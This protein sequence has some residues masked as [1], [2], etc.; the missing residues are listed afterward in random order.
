MTTVDVARPRTRSDDRRLVACLIFG[1]LSGATVSGFGNP[2]VPE[3]A[4]TQG[5]S[6]EAAQWT[7]TITLIVGAIITPVVS[8][9]GDGFRRRR[10]FIAA[11]AAIATGSVIPAVFASFPGLLVGRSLQGLGYALVPITIAIASQHLP[12]PVLRRTLAWLSLS[13]AIGAGLA[14]PIIGLFVRYLDYRAA[15]LFAAA[16]AVSGALVAW[17]VVPRSPTDG[18]PLGVDVPGGVLLAIGLGSGL[19]AVSRGDA[20]GWTSAS[21]VA[22]AASSFVALG[23]WVC[24]ELRVP[25]PLVDVRLASSPHLL[26]VNVTALTTGAAVFGGMSVVYRL[27]Q[28]PTQAPAGLGQPLLVAGLMMLPLSFGSVLS[29]GLCRWLERWLSDRLTLALASVIMAAAFVYFAWAHTSL[30][31]I[32]VVTFVVGLGFGIAYS[33][34]PAM[35]VATAPPE[36]TSSASGVN[37]VLRI[38]GG[39][40]GGAVIAA[41]LAASTPAGEDFPTEAGIVVA[42]ITAA[43]L[44]VVAMLASLAFVR[45]LPPRVNLIGETVPD[46]VSGL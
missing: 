1:A 36:R 30:V 19:L 31:Q 41:L 16:L 20:W 2:L 3:V 17:R 6:L 40:I 15:F 39:A 13:V 34:M 37:T 11:L 25:S 9:L 38:T 10:I 26:G 29:P 12:G 8:R 7:L 21:V 42:A 27:I 4:R 43:A 5:V 46:P 28:A 23:S 14:N 18:P 45:S 24:V 32:A 44:C 22:L 33:V 35:I